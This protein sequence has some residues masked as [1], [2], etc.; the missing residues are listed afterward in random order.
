MKTTKTIYTNGK[1]LFTLA[2]YDKVSGHCE[3]HGIQ[4]HSEVSLLTARAMHE[5]GKLHYVYGIGDRKELSNVAL[6]RSMKL[7]NF[8]IH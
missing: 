8:E 3:A 5:K 2:N 1:S 7:Q 6:N 4:F